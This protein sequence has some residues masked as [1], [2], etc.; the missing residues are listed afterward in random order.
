MNSHQKM[1]SFSIFYLFKIKANGIILID[2]ASHPASMTHL[3]RK[4]RRV[5]VISPSEGVQQYCTV[6][7][8]IQG[9]STT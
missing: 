5:S 8:L 4:L 6:M 1:F 7:L 3:S 9:D 2:G